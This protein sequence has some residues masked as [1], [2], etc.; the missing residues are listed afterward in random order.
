MLGVVALALASCTN[1][2]VLNVSDSRAIGFDAFVNNNTKAVTEVNKDNLNKDFYVFGDYKEGNSVAFNNTKAIKGEKGFIPETPAYWKD[3]ETYTFGAYADGIDASGN[4]GKIEGATF[5]NGTLT[6]PGYTVSDAKDLVAVTVTDIVAPTAEVENTPIS[7]TFKH[8]LAKIKFTFNTNASP[9]AY[10]M[11]VT[12]LT[13]DGI[14]TGA[15]CVLDGEGNVTWT[16]TEGTYTLSEVADYVQGKKSTQDIL[17]IPQDNS[18]LNATFTVTVKDRNSGAE[19]A[20]NEFTTSIST[21][22]WQPGYYYN[23]TATINPDDVDENMRPIIFDVEEVDGWTGSDK[24]IT[25]TPQ[26]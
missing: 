7:M 23:Y 5:S 8:M 4:A 6:I 12:G 3:G 15:T 25:P 20:S 14:K 26:P 21:D 1:E 16:G 2:E 17:V 9:A 22:T 18:E 19:V 13:F 11:S 10:I 24:P